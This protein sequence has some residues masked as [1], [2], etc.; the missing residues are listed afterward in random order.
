MLVDAEQIAEVVTRWTG[1]PLTR[2]SLEESFQYVGLEELIRER[3][4][5]QNHAVALV[6]SVRSSAVQTRSP[7]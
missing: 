5:G 4:K 7:Y 6:V 2:L 1:I 3:V